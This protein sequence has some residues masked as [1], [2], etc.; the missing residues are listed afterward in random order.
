MRFLGFLMIVGQVILAPL[1]TKAAEP[2]LPGREIQVEINF[3]VE[4]VA[5]CFE[6]ADMGNWNLSFE[7]HQP[8]KAKARERFGPFRDHEAIRLVDRMVKRGFWLDAMLEVALKTTPL[9]DA[10][11]VRDLD[12]S[13]LLR[14]SEDL[15]EAR[16]LVLEFIEALSDFYIHADLAG[17]F[18]EN[19]AYYASVIR[20]V[21]S[22]LPGRDFVKTMEDFYGKQN[23]A[24]TLV[25]SPTIWHTMGFGPRL[26]GEHG[27]EVFNIFGPVVVT[28]DPE[29]FGFG[30]NHREAIE[31][32]SVHEF[33]HSFVN[34]LSETPE[35][36]EKIAGFSY[37][38]MPVKSR[39]ERQGYT[40]W[41]TCATE[42]LV[43]LGE[44]RIAY[45]MGDSARAERIREDYLQRGFIYLPYLEEGIL[46]Y[47]ENRDVYPMFAD[48]LP[49]LL[50]SFTHAGRPGISWMRIG[51]PWILIVTGVL[52]IVGL[53]IGIYKFPVRK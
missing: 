53:A 6:I 28:K 10:R 3:N 1:P 43:R 19:R 32:L 4:T 17:F 35:M 27:F 9:P 36:R 11:L 47:E 25:P 13:N 23:D 31:E 30:Y 46:E 50:G 39:M 49:A 40:D 33:G 5:I 44:I 34:P 21:R 15:S 24:Y 8:M 51:R 2:L 22:N 26:R 16:Q 48:F 37:L 12:E 18:D 45:A 38:Y 41:Q 29:V 20:E 52:L 7:S 42:H 14:L